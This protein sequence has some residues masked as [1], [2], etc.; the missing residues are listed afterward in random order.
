MILFAQNFEHFTSDRNCG[1]LYNSCMWKTS[2]MFFPVILGASTTHRT[3]SENPVLPQA[4]V[5]FPSLANIKTKSEIFIRHFVHLFAYMANGWREHKWV[6]VIARDSYMIHRN[7]VLTHRH[8]RSGHIDIIHCNF[9]RL[10]SCENLL[11]SSPPSA[12]MWP[13]HLTS[14][15]RTTPRLPAAR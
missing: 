3:G 5:A 11:Y 13:G 6:K 2:I 8:H 10:I 7:F 9:T 14:R 1:K 15:R 12:W 4:G